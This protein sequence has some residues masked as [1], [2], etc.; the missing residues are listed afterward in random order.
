MPQTVMKIVIT[1]TGMSWFNIT[2]VVAFTWHLASDIRA[3][4]TW[5]HELKT[6]TGILANQETVPIASVSVSPHNLL[7]S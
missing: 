6:E 2:V 3:M 5:Q 4:N 7:N 1:P